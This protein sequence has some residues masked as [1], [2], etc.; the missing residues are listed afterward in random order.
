M[1]AGPMDD[2]AKTH[3]IEETAGL[4]Q[5][6]SDPNAPENIGDFVAIF[7]EN[8]PP[9]DLAGRTPKEL[10]EAVQSFYAHARTRP[11]DTPIISVHTPKARLANGQPAH[12]VVQI[13][14][15]DMPFIV[16]SMS[17]ALNQHGV[18]VHLII[19]PILHVTRDS[20]GKIAALDWHRP[21]D[22]ESRAESW[23]R[24][25]ID[26]H[27]KAADVQAIKDRLDA[28]LDDVRASVRDWKS[29][30]D[31][32]RGIVDDLI[33]APPDL[34]RD[35]IAEAK[36]FLNWIA[37][38]H[39]TLLGC[40][41]YRFEQG[42]GTRNKPQ[43]M[44]LVEGSGRGLLRHDGIPVFDDP[45]IDD[46]LPRRVEAFLNSPNIVSV[47][48]A[49][50]RSTVHRPVHL[51]A[52]TVKQFDGRGRVTGEHVFVGLFTSDV[53]TS[54][55]S[56]VPLIRLKIQ[57]AIEQARFRPASHDRKALQHIFLTYPRD[58]L[59][60]ISLDD[61]TRI[62][63]GVLHLQERQRTALFERYDDF[64]SYVS[65]LVYVPRD[66]FNTALR[67]AFTEILETDFSGQI[68]AFYTQVSDDSV[69]ARLHFIIKTDSAVSRHTDIK[70]T[71][72]K[73][74]EATR[75]WSDRLQEALVNAHGE[76]TGLGLMRRYDGAF[77]AGYCAETECALAVTDIA[78]IEQA[79]D[80]QI[81]QM[82]MRRGAADGN[83]GFRFRIFN[84]GG[85][86]PLSDTLP[87]LE[88]MGLRIIDEAPYVVHPNGG[89]PVSIH[90]F[91][92]AVQ[93]PDSGDPL[94]LQE[95]FEE[96]FARV[97]SGDM[98]ADW[99]NALVLA[100]GLDW[101]GIV[102]L[103]AYAR[104]LR[105]AGVPFSIDYIQRALVSN[106]ALAARIVDLF[107]DR[108]EKSGAEAAA[109][110]E[111]I[112]TRL[113]DV[114]S[115]D[116]DRIIRR[117]VN[118][119]QATLRTNYSQT[120]PDGGIKPWLSF[121]LDSQAITELPL[122]RPMVE[123]W[124]Y[125][126]RVEGVHLRFGKVARGGLRW[127]DR[128][129]DFRTEILGLVKAQVVKNA[130]I[131]PVGSKGGFV[132]KQPPVGGDR[133]AQLEE[134]IACYQTF[135]RGMLDITDNI[136]G[137]AIVPP[138]DVRRYDEDDPYLVVAADKGTA[139]FSD[140]ANGISEDYGF[141]LGDA[142][143][144][145]GSAGYDHKKMGIT[146]RGAW[147]AVKRHFRE[148][149]IDTQTTE[150]DVVGVGDMGGDVFGN[151][152]L[153]SEHIRLVAAFNHLHIFV[154]PTPDAASSYAERQRL[155][156]E[157]KG[158]DAYNTDLISEGGGVF[159][160]AAKSIELTPQMKSRFGLKSNALT[161]NE[162]IQ[163]ILGA[164]TDL[165]WFG[166][167]GTYIKAST[168][169]DL[170]VGD[171]ANDA[172]RLNGREIRAKVIGE[173]ANLG[174]TQL[175]RVEFGL[176]GGRI[177]TDSIDNSAGVDCS[178]HEVNI[179]VLLRSA[180]ERGDLTLK[181]RNRLLERMTDE[182]AEL[183]LRDNY[184]QTQQISVTES[185]GT[186][187]VGRL[188]RLMRTLEREGVLD[189]EVEELPEDD[190]LEDRLAHG[191]SLT[192]PEL[193]ILS[194][195][196]KI[197]LFDRL[198]D[199][200]LPDDPYLLDDLVLYFPTPLRKAYRSDIESHRLRREIIATL[201][202]N[203]V[204]NRAG[205]TF[206]RDAMSETGASA[207]DVTRAYIMAREVFDMRDVW[208]K[209][210][211]LDNTLPTG[212]QYNVYLASGRLIQRAVPWFIKAS[213]RPMDIARTVE[214]IQPGL[215]KFRKSLDKL[216]GPESFA[217]FEKGCAAMGET[218]FSP[219]LARAVAEHPFLLSGC[220]IVLLAAR[221]GRSLNA[222]AKVYFEAGDRFGL[223][224]LRH[225][226]RATMPRL[227]WDKLAVSA[228][229]DDIYSHQS[230][231]VEQALDDGAA[232]GRALDT[233]SK[234][235]PQAIEQFERL[236]Q[237]VQSSDD[238]DLAMLAVANRQLGA[239][240]AP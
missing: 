148:M 145:G 230:R 5:A 136:V 203:S 235:R 141:W 234:D 54:S 174:V 224:W 133:A 15:D 87:I 201:A 206:V 26:Q 196:A 94:A 195:Y 128:H 96:A 187:S 92:V 23:V 202:T 12:T 140:I 40:R 169:Q 119:V 56:D 43:R 210:Q 125:S 191:K 34:P 41:E 223:D 111:D 31:R 76:E 200:D 188:A 181:A 170:D 156:D 6:A 113:N 10:L 55:A 132:V 120:L 151:G 46:G 193:A 53:Y 60:Q 199:S 109:I 68:T 153:L 52:V 217:Q 115:L 30:L 105:Q 79:L 164:E 20:D 171:R 84:V 65:C 185:L 124:V 208:G 176:A 19:H 135:I 21:R 89:P 101:R 212:G 85:P 194:S 166:G 86:V 91:G 64:N 47:S 226:A 238:V 83:G 11:A 232:A 161:P 144:S 180:A 48:K 219:P 99:F 150:F 108:F 18:T 110:A 152:M 168:E 95:I 228:V 22:E 205:S 3:L 45:D 211:E 121:K 178:D 81:L 70:G 177:N 9:D 139:T 118:L 225:K 172:I 218:G 17:A 57:R 88:H 182:V 25:E 4:W 72:A 154:D 73:L 71:E 44:V 189:R 27:T 106:A 50:V 143:A 126:P 179:K 13:V 137:Q 32:V 127:S 183:V 80:S 146:A 147:E 221:H 58:E 63:M 123:I 231:I 49:N 186:S 184:M 77:G 142:F 216:L 38:N 159:S 62:G 237:D 204:V 155:F 66:R 107:R 42:N 7:F 233:W 240:T 67:E 102:V 100:A 190:V 207:E 90:D 74:A 82:A 14:N 37:D 103:R 192:R 222:V 213:G 29:M 39:F 69:L 16:D 129:E 78:L 33:V 220:D 2:R 215:R 239:L 51:D 93:S 229:I 163:A 157:V 167:I 117:L 122:P 175:G 116:E 236:L 97:W 98:E 35:D 114:A 227:H 8:V 134:G 138:D 24:I 75:N 61:L 214:A 59:F 198:L 1:V 158:W 130:V 173:G 197:D 112:E 131:V 165:L 104:Y 36:S 160:R 149:G 162:L 28:V 209:L